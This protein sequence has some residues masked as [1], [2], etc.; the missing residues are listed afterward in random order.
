MV[1]DKTSASEITPT[2]RLAFSERRA[3]SI[4]YSEEDA[5]EIIGMTF[6]TILVFIAF[7]LLGSISYGLVVCI[8]LLFSPPIE[9][10]GQWKSFADEAKV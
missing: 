8:R 3:S 2:I 7:L 4:N 10:V 9:T 5:D 6:L 1:A